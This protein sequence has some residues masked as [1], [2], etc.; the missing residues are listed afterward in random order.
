MISENIRALITYR[1]E[2]AEECILAARLLL[3]E[4]LLRAAVNRAYYAMFYAVLALLAGRREGTSKHTGAISLFDREYVKP[5][6][7]PKDFSRWLHEAFELRQ[8]SDYGVELQL[9]REEIR[10]MLA[11][12]AEFVQTVKSVLH[13]DFPA[14]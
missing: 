11:H 7:F 8:R 10:E 6:I 12:A 5:G 13:S 1:L 9:S 3:A 4:R 2:Q 14:E